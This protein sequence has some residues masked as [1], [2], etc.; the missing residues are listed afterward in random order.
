MNIVAIAISLFAPWLLF[1]TIFAVMTFSIHYLQPLFAYAVVG[2]GFLVVIV[3]GVLAFH[4]VR[5]RA[6]ND[7]RS[8]PTWY[9]FTFGSCVIAWTLSLVGGDIN[10]Y[11]NMQPFYDIMNL[12][13]YPSVDPSRMRGQQLMDAGR[14]VFTDDARLDIKKSMGF[15]N[16]DI[17]C[18]APITVG[19][20]NVSHMPLA[21]YD[22]WAVGV[23]CCSGDG[24]DFNCGDFNNPRA[25]SG[26]RLMR[27]DQRA[28]FRL[29]VQQAEAAYNLKGDHPL[30]F[31]WMQDPMLAVAN[32]QDEGFK[33]YLVGM[34][35]H[36]LFQ[37]FMVTGA[38]LAFSKM[39]QF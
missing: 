23:N 12:N 5:M 17:Y 1:N 28:Y 19:N 31:Y 30:F 18:V 29:A 13:T 25:H 38:V 7:P 3:S 20:Q 11:H 21:T 37:L 15:K 35:S 14:I 10:F 26:L 32:Y 34:L 27:D 24:A 6:L 2:F 22:F 33:W 9:I 36:F 8:E 4:A 39:G 16:L